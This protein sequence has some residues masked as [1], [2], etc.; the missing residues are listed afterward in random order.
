MRKLR[1][2]ISCFLGLSVLLSAIAIAD[3]APIMNWMILDLPPASMPVS[4][5]PTDGVS[6]V[7]LKLIAKEWPE[8]D[9]RYVVVTTARA[10]ETL[11]HG[12]QSCFGSAL[13]TPERENVAYFSLT[14]VAPPL[15]VVVHKALAST[16]ETDATG[17]ILPA[18]LFDRKD[19]RGIVMYQRSYPPV[20]DALLN[21]RLTAIES[22][23]SNITYASSADGGLNF[24]KMIM[25]RRADYTLEHNFVLGY[26]MKKHSTDFVADP[27]RSMEVAGTEPIYVG[28][29][30]PHTDWGRRAILKID[31]ILAKIAMN[32]EYQDSMNRWLTPEVRKRYKLL[33]TKFFNNR[34]R[35]TESARYQ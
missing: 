4:G 34:K 30:C 20:L 9:H 13:Y 25:M 3:E 12:E 31:A 33:Q 24:L 23:Q 14:H 17:K 15:Q 28:I 21:I 18:T 16:L 27:L 26:Q 22:R 32:P 8:V 5:L 35:L 7:A 11:K 29:A 2:L 1:N 19:L 10:M 6:D